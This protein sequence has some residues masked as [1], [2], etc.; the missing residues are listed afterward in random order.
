MV[1]HK[2]PCFVQTFLWDENFCNGPQ[3]DEVFGRAVGRMRS[4]RPITLEPGDG[5]M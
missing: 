1:T 2:E 3:P 5:S 4:S